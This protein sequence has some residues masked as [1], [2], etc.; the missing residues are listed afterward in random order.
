MKTGRTD[1]KSGLEP[2]V[3]VEQAAA[4]CC[5]IDEEGAIKIL[6]IS[7]KDTGRCVLPKGFVGK[8]EPTFRRAQR[9]ALEEAGVIGKVR[10]KPLGY[11]TY[12]EDSENRLCVTVHLL[13]FERKTSDYREKPGSDKIWVSASVASCHVN[14]PGLSSL[15]TLL[16][17]NNYLASQDKL[18]LRKIASRAA[19]RN[20]MRRG[21]YDQCDPSGLETG[22]SGHSF[23]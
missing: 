2:E 20:R 11:Y 14:E 6:L 13:R 1:G 15:L 23:M 19:N 9:E 7:N 18:I 5:R 8:N 21:V 17:T 22:D 12:S 3:K 10:K 4:I 16:S